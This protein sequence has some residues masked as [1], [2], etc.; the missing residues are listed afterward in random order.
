MRNT[1]NNK[2]ITLIA[3]VITIIVLL[4]LAGVAI[5]TLTGE[6]GIL[7]KAATA[8]EKTKEETAKE[9]IKIAVMG[10]YGED[11]KLQ[12]EQ[13]REEIKKQGGEIIEDESTDEYFVVEIDG[14][15]AKVDKQTGEILEFESA[16]GVKPEV[17]ANLYQTD[18]S[19]LVSGTSYEK[20]VITVKIPNKDSLGNIDEII[21]KDKNGTVINKETS[22]IGEGEAS[23]I[24]AGT[25]TYTITV[26]ATT[27][28]GTKTTTITQ[29][30]K[31]APE[32][33]EI[34]TKEDA[35]WYNYGNARIN[36]PKLAGEMTPIKY[37]GE[38]QEG[39][40]WANSTTQD[41]SMWVWI[42]RYAYKIT[43][44]Y[45]SSTAGTIEIAFLDTKDN[46]LNGETGEITRNLNDSGAATT[47]WLVHPA[48][49]SDA[50]AGGGFGELEG[51]W[52]G[53]F[54]TAGSTSALKVV[55]GVPSMTSYNKRINDFY[56][57]AKKSKFGENV[58][59]MSHMAKNSEWGAIA[60]LAHSQF[61]TRRT[62]S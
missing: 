59:L 60:Y 33:W 42:P 6:N 61:G 4:I 34:T 8:N 51:L 22:V 18:G 13:F 17:K 50:A 14:Y 16:K 46:F 23:F 1:K 48:F 44:G 5:A 32:Y 2:G 39:N 56:L 12:E 40:K 49:T 15:K 35:Q 26:K 20:V 36:E 31:V 41:G 37:I 9:K 28:G 30:V 53:K 62:R 19:G 55:P 29:S 24:V 45:H 43:S 10:S 52:V 57:V 11:G 7:K 47:K 54:E 38:E 3:L 58:E 27:D 25:G 21:V